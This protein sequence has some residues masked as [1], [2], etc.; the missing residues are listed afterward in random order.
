MEKLQK[1]EQKKQVFKLQS[2]ISKFNGDIKS[3]KQVCTSLIEEIKDQ[4]G[5]IQKSEE[6]KIEKGHKQIQ[7]TVN[8]GIKKHQKL[9]ESTVNYGLKKITFSENQME[10]DF[11]HNPNTQ[12]VK[13]NKSSENQNSNLRHQKNVISK[14]NESNNPYNS[15]TKLHI[16]KHKTHNSNNPYE[17]E[18][19]ESNEPQYIPKEE[20]DEDNLSFDIDQGQQNAI[21]E[22]MNFPK[23]TVKEYFVDN[24]DDHEINQKSE[25]NGFESN[26]QKPKPGPL[27]DRQIYE[28]FYQNVEETKHKEAAERESI[29][30]AGLY[31]VFFENLK[32]Q[33]TLQS[34]KQIKV[35][36]E[37]DLLNES[38]QSIKDTLFND[39]DTNQTNVKDNY[40]KLPTHAKMIHQS[41]HKGT[42]LNFMKSHDINNRPNVGYY[43]HNSKQ[44]AQPMFETTQVSRSDIY[45]KNDTTNVEY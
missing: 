35:N 6:N 39:F 27:N 8:Y 31:G 9:T 32:N 40:L 4:N 2:T 1:D 3:L 45:G 17:I 42:Q 21:I 33:T 43:D 12:K 14:S 15:E 20:I 19:I 25:N 24:L 10:N 34:T 29:N 18:T 36:S 7:S 37:R 38:Q 23:N 13:N 5:V 16:R 22:E 28:L 44:Q 11:G 30:S 26:A 41:V